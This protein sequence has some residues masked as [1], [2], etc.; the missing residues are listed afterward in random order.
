MGWMS[1]RKMESGKYAR[2]ERWIL[3]NLPIGKSKP[4][5]TRLLG[6]PVIPPKYGQVDRHNNHTP[7]KDKKNEMHIFKGFEDQSDTYHDTWTHYLMEKD[8]FLLQ[9]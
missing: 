5:G 2:S 4:M 9:D 7:V 1:G 8:P 3:M 6:H